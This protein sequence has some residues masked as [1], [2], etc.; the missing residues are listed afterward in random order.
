MA[1]KIRGKVEVKAVVPAEVVASVTSGKGEAA[2]TAL[3]N[4]LSIN[5]KPE[6][7]TKEQRQARIMRRR[8]ICQAFNISAPDLDN[9]LADYKKYQGNEQPSQNEADILRDKRDVSR[10]QQGEVRAGNRALRDSV[11]NT[12]S[13]IATAVSFAVSPWL[14][15]VL[16]VVGLGFDIY[17]NRKAQVGK[18]A[19]GTEKDRD[20]IEALNVFMDKIEKFNQILDSEMEE[21]M[22]KKKTMKAKEFTAYFKTKMLEL[23]DKMKA[24]GIEVTITT[25]ENEAEEAAQQ[26]AEEEKTESE[27]ESSEEE[28]EQSEEAEQETE[29]PEEG[30]EESE[31]KSKKEKKSRRQKRLKAEEERKLQEESK[32]EEQMEA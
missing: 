3:Y 28:K 23:R 7:E 2:A 14:T 30:K 24:Q 18:I 21:I 31:V 8:L 19:D 25:Q 15:I 29:S 6:G 9:F 26:M 27:A 17:R 20:Y 11:V 4:S 10:G 16:A 32:I 5:V 12:A 1:K 13:K 22:S